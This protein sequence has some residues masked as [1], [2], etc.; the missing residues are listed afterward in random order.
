MR[1]FF[2]LS[3]I[4]FFH[5]T[6]TTKA[7]GQTVEEEATKILKRAIT[8]HGGR[9]KL[10]MLEKFYI[11][12]RF[13]Q[14]DGLDSAELWSELPD[15]RKK[16]FHQVANN[17]Q[18]RSV[19]TVAVADE[20]RLKIPNEGARPMNEVQ[21]RYEKEARYQL[22]ARLLYPILEKKDVFRAIFRGEVERGKR[23]TQHV[24]VCS[25]GQ[26][27]LELFFEKKTGLLVEFSSKTVALEAKGR[28]F[29]TRFLEFKDFAGLI[30]PKR[31]MSL[32]DDEPMGEPDEVLEMRFLEEFP[33][34]TFD[35]PDPVD[36]Q[37]AKVLTRAMAAHGGREKLAMLEKVYIKV[38]LKPQGEITPSTEEWMEF[39]YKRKAA[40]H[41]DFSNG[42]KLTAYLV[43][44]GDQGWVKLPEEASNF[45]G[46]ELKFTNGQ[47]LYRDY[48][49]LLYPI[50]EK[51]DTFQAIYR[52]EIERG[53][54]LMQRVTVRA[55]TQLDVDL[56]FEKTTGRLVEMSSGSLR[57]GPKG[58]N[59]LK[60]FL[61]FQDYSGLIYPR[62]EMSF[63]D[64]EQLTD[65]EVLEIRF[66]KAF[67]K[68]TF[69]KP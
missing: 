9:D 61:D 17:G 1:A 29:V 12:V 40:A 11:K 15:S 59:D 54:R 23:L 20:G 45:M 34:G 32:F 38:Q 30:Y 2:V 44:N 19:F 56:F 52:G 39:P 21:V 64:D 13:D 46:E 67:P 68:G 47:H 63:V 28:S 43:Q 10:A 4:F 16:V 25:K 22:Y 26:F 18:K 8:A 62:R 50:L 5:A 42:T 57:A 6:T 37:A 51:K 69:D 53:N 36:E 58:R 41:E 66:L 65:G 7:F 60:R 48:L 3:I 14:K 35:L 55:E 31:V 33:K 49:R 24:T 27:D